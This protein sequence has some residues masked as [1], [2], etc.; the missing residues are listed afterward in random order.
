[1]S[2]Q[3]LAY[4]LLFFPPDPVMLEDGF[5]GYLSLEWG[6]EGEWSRSNDTAFGSNAI[7]P[8]SFHGVDFINFCKRQIETYVKHE[9]VLNVD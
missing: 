2:C 5:L 3:H 9:V 1:M 6:R 4:E 8:S 7:K